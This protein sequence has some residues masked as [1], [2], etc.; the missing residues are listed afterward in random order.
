MSVAEGSGAVGGVDDGGRDGADGEVA[1]WRRLEELFAAAVGLPAAERAAF[2]DAACDDRALRAE[3]EA[4]LAADG[5]AGGFVAAAVAAGARAFADRVADAGVEAAAGRRLGAYRLLGEIG[6]GGMSSVF[7]AR[8]DDDAFEQQVAIKLILPGFESGEILRRFLAE[9]RILA[10]LDHPYIARLHD[11]GT[12]ADGRPYFVMEHVDGEPIDAWCDRRRLPTAERLRLFVKVCEA[13]HAAHRNLVVHRDLKPSNVLVTAGGDP[14]LLDFGIAKP[15]DRDLVAGEATLTGM[16]PMTPRYASPEQ[17]AGGPVTTASDVYSLGVLLYRLLTGRLPQARTGRTT[18]EWVRAV[19]EEP[20]EAP[21]RAVVR[22]GDG[23]SPEAVAA[24]RDGG[25]DALRRRLAGDLDNVVA[26]ALD[27]EPD[28]R[29]GSAEQLA[30]DVVRHLAGHP[31]IARPATARYR[32]AKFLRRH[33]L[34]TAAALLALAAVVATTVLFAVQARRVASER[35]RANQVADLLADLFALAD[36]RQARGGSITA[37]ELLDRGAERV[38]ALDGQPRTQS[39][40]LGKLAEL[41]EPLGLFDEAA[42]LLRRALAIERTLEAG[43]GG[44]RR[45]MAVRLNHLGRVVARQGDYAAAEALFAEA[46]VRFERLSGA[47]SEDVALML[48]NLALA[49]HDLGDY[50]AA[51]DGYRRSIDLETRLAGAPH[52]FTLGNYAL[53]LTDLGDYAE[54]EA[55]LTRSVAVERRADDDGETLASGLD[56]LGL[57]LLA[58]GEHGA[59]EAAFAEALTLRRALFGDDHP[60]TMRTLGAIGVLARERGEL[61]AAERLLERSLAE[62]RRALGDA[63]PEVAEGLREW[64]LLAALAGRDEEAEAAYREALDIQRRALSERHPLTGLTAGGL[65]A[66]LA[67]GGDC[68]AALPLLEAA[69]ELVP[70]RDWRRPRAAAA[71]ETCAGRPR[72]ARDP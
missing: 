21:S 68:A 25:V 61:A 48:N 51:A 6:R 69:L 9:R 14:K 11:A 19:L 10:R 35:D 66:L 50:A 67:A 16:R 52:P 27:R 34:A 72:A 17:I 1:F 37:R 53:L 32:L 24:L 59:A 43:A 4:L 38:A 58:Q 23:P 2:L 62:R 7:L 57:A 28:R 46:A 22:R 41:Y 18:A 42:E 39:M 33:R 26:K 30:E 8:R 65:G 55:I 71:L 64:A 49:R 40:L 45:E 29:Y 44:E 63:H 31:V 36:P 3:V 20:P 13:V 12:T 5:A 56:H 60:E 54:A 47:D 70:E 15:L